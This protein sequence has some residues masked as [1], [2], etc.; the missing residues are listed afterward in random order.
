MLQNL[1]EKRKKHATDRVLQ[2]VLIF[3]KPMNDDFNI[4]IN[5]QLFVAFCLWR[6]ALSIHLKHL[7]DV[8]QLF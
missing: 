2:H 1:N 7:P 3:K 5:L 6:N 4:R 8:I